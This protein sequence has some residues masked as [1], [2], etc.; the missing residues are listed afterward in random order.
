MRRTGTSV[1]IEDV[2]FPVDAMRDIRNAK[3]GRQ[4]RPE[5]GS[6]MRLGRG[7]ARAGSK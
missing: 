3:I 5:K 1:I 6:L 2:A 7:V 4:Q